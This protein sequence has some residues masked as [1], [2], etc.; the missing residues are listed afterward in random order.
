MNEETVKFLEERTVGVIG[1]S[2]DNTPHCVPIYYYFDKDAE[3]FY[4]VTKSKTQKAENIVSNSKV[5]ITV[6]SEEPQ[7]TFGARCDATILESNDADQ[8]RVINELIGVHSGQ[9]YF[10]TPLSALKDGDLTLVKLKI[11][12]HNFSFYKQ[13]L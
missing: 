11:E 5:F 13:K 8:K 7:A 4:F 10:P 1:T 9:E 2:K 3:S 12:D 6:F